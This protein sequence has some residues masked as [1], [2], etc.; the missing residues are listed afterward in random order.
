MTLTIADTSTTASRK[1][2]AKMMLK[3][4]DRDQSISNHTR[5]GKKPVPIISKASRSC[6]GMCGGVMGFAS[7]R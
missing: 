1:T 6:S 4:R 2:M 5:Q 7:P 3:L